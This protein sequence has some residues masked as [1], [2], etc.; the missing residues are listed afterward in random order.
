MQRN[1]TIK[2]EVNC[3]I[4]FDSIKTWFFRRVS[5][6]Q[7]AIDGGASPQV[8]HVEREKIKRDPGK[9]ERDSGGV[10]SRFG[11]IGY[12]RSLCVVFP[13]VSCY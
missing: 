13:L 10:S 11:Q 8:A 4:S 2:I 1:I 6:L 12:E 7:E 3:L 5:K 9:V